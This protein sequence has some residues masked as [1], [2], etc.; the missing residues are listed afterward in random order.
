[1]TTTS[2]PAF[3][4]TP[5]APMISA[6]T[7][8]T[9]T[10]AIDPPS[11]AA[12]TPTVI[13]F[14]PVTL[15]TVVAAALSRSVDAIAVYGSL[16]TAIAGHTGSQCT[17]ELLTDS[18]VC[19]IETQTA[20]PSPAPEPLVTE[21]ASLSPIARRLLTG[22]GSPLSGPDWF[23]LPIGVAAADS[24]DADSP[25]GCFTCRVPSRQTGQTQL[26][27]TQYLLSLASE[28]LQAE[29]RVAKAQNQVV[30]LEIALKSNRDIGTAIGILMNAHLVTH[31]QAFTM[32][33][34]V[35][36]HNHRKLRDV[37]NDVIFTGGLSPATPPAKPR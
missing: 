26:E 21:Q 11:T 23:A 32:L 18:R 29:R 14:E 1:M 15:I 35:S 16:A 10:P 5:G 17:V 27:A 13:A 33:R 9:S 6:A 30:N 7:D 24:A 25:V 37:A 31:E 28:V 3:F 8:T 36:Q 19:L 4:S 12:A 2:I 22:D 20:P 34:T